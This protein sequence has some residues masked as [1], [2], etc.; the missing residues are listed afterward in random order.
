[1][2]RNIN[3]NACLY[4]RIKTPGPKRLI[5]MGFIFV[6]KIVQNGQKIQ[7]MLMKE[8]CATIK[9]YLPIFND[10][11]YKYDAHSYKLL[12]LEY[13]PMSKS[14]TESLTYLVTSVVCS[15][16]TAFQIISTQFEVLYRTYDKYNGPQTF[17]SKTK[18]SPPPPK[19]TV[20]ISC[21][22]Q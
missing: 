2:L 9:K 13:F 17:W 1:M 12:L 5:G 16:K 18:I 15:H 8:T 22:P 19:E 7:N 10:I 20:Y 14:C 6:I 3:Y 11:Y 4:W 21:S